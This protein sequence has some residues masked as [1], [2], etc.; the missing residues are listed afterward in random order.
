[1]K[2]TRARW[3]HQRRNNGRKAAW[4]MGKDRNHCLHQTNRLGRCRSRFHRWRQAPLVFDTFPNQVVL[5]PIMIPM[6][7]ASRFFYGYLLTER[8]SCAVFFSFH[9]KIV[10]FTQ[11]Q[12][13]MLETGSIQ[14]MWKSIPKED[15]YFHLVLNWPGIVL[16]YAIKNT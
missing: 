5:A 3:S 10:I 16:K 8:F 6:R 14:S 13:A 4:P 11:V 7:S 1:M 12:N 2:H 15:V 9:F